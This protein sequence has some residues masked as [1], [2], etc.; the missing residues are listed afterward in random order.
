MSI[1]TPDGLEPA[2]A[3]HLDVATLPNT[4]TPEIDTTKENE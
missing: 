1:G 4:P 3:D 2:Y